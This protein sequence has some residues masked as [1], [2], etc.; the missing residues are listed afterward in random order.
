LRQRIIVAPAW[1]TTHSSSSSI[2]MTELLKDGGAVLAQAVIVC[3]AR[4]AVMCQRSK[5][6]LK[7]PHLT[8]AHARPCGT[9]KAHITPPY[10]AR[11][12]CST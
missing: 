2:R 9:D 3:S 6:L 1:Q 12:L 7:K 5:L 10:K 8:W 11:N 4:H